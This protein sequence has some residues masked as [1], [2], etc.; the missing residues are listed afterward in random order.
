M[1]RATRFLIV[2]AC[3]ATCL[4]T[5]TAY[6]ASL[7]NAPDQPAYT[8][9]AGGE[10][11]A[12]ARSGD[13]IYI[14]GTFTSVN[15]QT[16]TNLA[17]FSAV[18]G[19]LTSWAPT[20]D[21]EVDALAVS[22]STI[23][24]GGLFTQVTG[25]VARNGAAAFDD[26][27]K[28]LAWDPHPNAASVAALLVEGSRVYLGGAFA[29]TNN[30]AVLSA[31][32]A[33][34]DPSTGAADAAWLPNPDASVN[35]LVSD[36]TFIYPIGGFGNVGGQ[37]R[38]GLAAVSIA[39]GAADAAWDPSDPAGGGFINAI[40]ISPDRSTIYVTGDFFATFGG[41]GV[42][43]PQCS[44][45]HADRSKGAGLET[46]GNGRIGNATPWDPNPDF[47]GDALAVGSSAVF[48]GVAGSTNFRWTT[49][50]VARNGV[51]ALDPVTGQPQAWDPAAND[52]VLAL[53]AATDGSVYVG[54]R[55]T[56]FTTQP[57]TAVGFASF[58][59][60]PESTS[61]PTVSGTPEAGQTLTCNNGTWLGATPQTYSPQFL[62][63]GQAV[64]AAG[65][66]TYTVA[67][68][69]A[70]H[71]LSCRMTAQNRVASASA[72]SAPLTIAALPV[73]VPPPAAPSGPPPPVLFRSV[74]IVPISGTVR[75]KLPGTTRFILIQDATSVPVGTIVDVTHGRVELV[76]AKDAKGATQT[77][78]FYGG[79]FK[80]V[81]LR[82]RPPITELIL[83][84]GSFKSCRARAAG[85]ALAAG[86]QSKRTI[87]HLWGVGKGAFRTKG[88][89]ASATIRGTKWLTAD[90][91]DGTLV[92]VVSGAV[93]VRDLVK[94][95]SRVV[96][97][98]HRYLARAPRKRR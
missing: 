78:T 39:S 75:V 40:A 81:Q 57:T 16:R 22:G 68:G 1:G 83:V 37:A 4:L 77:G 98:R 13:T 18:D 60:P 21:N 10:V 35:G 87:R 93:T 84:G 54:G 20:T 44:M 74:N 67:D 70:G 12:I 72:D 71:T 89:Y 73:V 27:G 92:R 56:A 96:R 2:A 32:L 45:G 11:H 47:E 30:G 86:K 88:R 23:Y 31:N 33:R 90:R 36:G 53:F 55:F 24:A 79:L 94:H 49:T 43:P 85:L 19:S 9:N 69:D 58:S 8:L 51:A 82:G 66:S 25:A 63:D 80:I 48:F 52:D 59:L 42:C 41:G 76:S 15:G 6:A 5:P 28:L 65:S 61:A 29:S 62:V 38:N 3:A 50:P 91:C 97:A 14:G 34:V 46:A 7:S 64:G 26:T 95:R 17:A